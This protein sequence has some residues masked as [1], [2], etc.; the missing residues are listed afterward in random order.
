MDTDAPLINYIL[1][2]LDLYAKNWFRFKFVSCVLTTSYTETWHF[3]TSNGCQTLGEFIMKQC[4][5]NTNT[6]L[7]REIS[8]LQYITLTAELILNRIFQVPTYVLRRNYVGDG[9]LTNAGDISEP[10]NVFLSL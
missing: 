4:T 10:L 6:I 2:V 9:T 3:Y 8:T 5:Y 7:L 1:A